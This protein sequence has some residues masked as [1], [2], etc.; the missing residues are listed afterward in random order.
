MFALDKFRSYLVSS[1]IIVF[2]D[3]AMLKYLLKKLDAKSR[4]ILWMLLL[5]EFDLEIKDKKGEENAIVYHLRRLEREADLM[6]IQDELLDEQILQM[7]HALPWYVDIYNYLIGSTYIAY[8]TRLESDVKYYIWDDPYLWRL[9]NDQIFCRCI[10][11]TKT[12][13]VLHFCHLAAGGG[14]YGSGRTA[15]KV[16]DSGIDIIGSFSVSQGNTYILLVVDYVSRW[17]EARATRANDAKTVVEIMKSNI[18]CKIGVLKALIN[19]QGSHFCN[20]NMAS[21]LEKYGVVHQ[22]STTYHPQIN[23][24]EEAFSREIKKKS[25]LERLE[26]PVRDALWVHRTAYQT[27]LGISPYQIVFDRACHLPV[28]IEHRAH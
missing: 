2:S 7:T 4:L 21:L 11:K 13:S 25:Q 6:S 26:P 15:R 1:K 22:V 5:Q 3:H 19:D 12:Q 28:A 8:K 16:L 17:V 27:L 23:D 18:F 10:S 9:C 24:Q 14:H 20:H